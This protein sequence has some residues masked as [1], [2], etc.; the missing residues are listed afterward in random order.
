MLASTPQLFKGVHPRA[1]F[2]HQ[3]GIVGLGADDRRS[4]SHASEFLF[5]QSRISLLYP[6]FPGGFQHALDHRFYF[7]GFLTPVTVAVRP[8]VGIVVH[9][10]L[11]GFRRLRE[12]APDSLLPGFLRLKAVDVPGVVRK[13]EE[14][15][16]GGLRLIHGVGDKSAHGFPGPRFRG[17]SVHAAH[18]QVGTAVVRNGEIPPDVGRALDSPVHPLLAF[19]RDVMADGIPRPH[20]VDGG[21]QA[22]AQNIQIS[23]RLG[24][25]PAAVVLRRAHDQGSD[26][27]LHLDKFVIDL[28]QQK[29]LHVPPLALSEDV[30]KKHG[31]GTD[32]QL[33][34]HLKLFDD[35]VHVF[36]RPLNVFAGVDGP[37]KVHMVFLRHL[38]QFPDLGGLVR[39]IGIPP[40]GGRVV[41]IVFRPVD[42]CVHFVLPVKAQLAQ[43]GFMA[44]GSA[45]KT[46]HR[47]A[48]FNVRPIR[49][50]PNGQN[51]AFS[52]GLR[53]Q[54]PQRLHGVKCPP[55]VMGSYAHLSLRRNHQLVG[56]GFFRNPVQ[57][58]APARLG[59]TYCHGRLPGES[60]RLGGEFGLLGGR[61]YGRSRR[62]SGTG[63]KGRHAQATLEKLKT[64]HD[65][66]R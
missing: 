30:V 26:V 61:I 21:V 58:L 15:N 62:Q 51:H 9:K 55:F 4:G 50:F 14:G 63:Q 16:L 3:P 17:K 38:H 54:L 25:G 59:G 57:Q 36:F 65:D 41:G 23:S 40:V 39:G 66:A 48:E 24:I 64:I 56:S 33:V 5:K 22:V 19:Q 42:V 52:A 13:T 47:S 10:N 46:F 43:T 20:N 53:S 8:L 49:N 29:G 11:H 60:N 28:V 45:V 1:D 44:P 6:A 31:K 35:V 18:A 12:Q 7:H 37:D 32:A 34:H 2:L 27:F